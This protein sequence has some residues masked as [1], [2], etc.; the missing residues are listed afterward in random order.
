MIPN[1]EEFQRNHFDYLEKLAYHP[2]ASHNK[3]VD[4]STNQSSAEENWSRGHVNEFLALVNGV[5]KSDVSNF[6]FNQF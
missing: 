4:F 2:L 3:D 5:A 6:W 1:N